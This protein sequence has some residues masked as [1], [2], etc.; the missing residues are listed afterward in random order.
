MFGMFG[1]F[2]FPEWFFVR[3]GSFKMFGR[4]GCLKCLRCLECLG[5]WAVWK[6]CKVWGVWK[7]LK[8]WKVWNVR[9]VWRV[10][11]F[12]S[13]GSPKV[14]EACKVLNVRNG[15]MIEMFGMLKCSD[16]L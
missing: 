16:G 10:L 8:V 15:E 4:L 14:G 6:V 9:N 3:L 13:K 7:V 12:F 5:G 2:G 1:S 11:G